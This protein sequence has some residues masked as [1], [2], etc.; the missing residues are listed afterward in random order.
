[1]HRRQRSEAI[2]QAAQVRA[3]V[4]PSPILRPLHQARPHR[5]EGYVPQRRREMW[6][7]HDDGAEPPLPEVTGSLASRLDNSGIGAMD[8]S[9][10]TVQT[11]R[12]GRHWDEVHVVWHQAPGRHL[13]PGV[14]AIR[15]EQ[16]TIERVV[17]ILEKG[18]RPAVATLSDVVGLTGNDDAGKT[19]HVLS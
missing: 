5:I 3:R 18:A 6:F 2:I 9:Q 12:I 19:G 10:R 16:V 14:R 15:S 4:R 13:D 1:M 7:V 8:P 11:V 17:A